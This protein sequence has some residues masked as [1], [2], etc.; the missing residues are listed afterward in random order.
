[1]LTRKTGCVSVCSVSPGTQR[2]DRLQFHMLPISGTAPLDSCFLHLHNMCFHLVLPC[3]YLRG[4]VSTRAVTEPISSV[5]NMCVCVGF[6]T[7]GKKSQNFVG[8]HWLRL[9]SA[10]ASGSLVSL[11]LPEFNDSN[12]R[13]G[14]GLSRRSQKVL[15]V[16]NK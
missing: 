9:A 8:L 3:Q 7:S 2:A 6:V 5:L 4:T 12:E 10:N 11:S 13:I 1:M 14:R 15:A 16:Q